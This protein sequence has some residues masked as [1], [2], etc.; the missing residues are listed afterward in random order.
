MF[1]KATLAEKV[2]ID[3]Q[4]LTAV[5]DVKYLGK[6]QQTMQVQFYKVL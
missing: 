6:L 5:D 3:C 1:N 2:K 4:D